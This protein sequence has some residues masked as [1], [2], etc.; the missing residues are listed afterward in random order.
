MNQRSQRLLTMLVFFALGALACASLPART[1]DAVL[2]DEDIVRMVLTGTPEKTI[3]ERIRTEPSDFDLSEEMVS[4]LRIAGLSRSVLQAM[5]DRYDE[6]NPEPE[7]DEGV[8][9]EVTLPP[10]LVI[11]FPS[12]KEDQ[13]LEPL[14]FPGLVPRALEEFLGL[15]GGDTDLKTTGAAL[16]VAC[17]SATHI[18]SHWR[19]RSPLGRDFNSMPRHELLKFY[20]EFEIDRTFLQKLAEKVSKKEEE[21]EE[22]P[23][24]VVRLTLPESIRLELDTTEPHDLL[25][26]VAIETGQRYMALATLE[27]PQLSVGPEGA[28]LSVAVSQKSRPSFRIDLK[29]AGNAN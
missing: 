14:V 9:A 20:P 22:S 8:A 11:H 21:E 2:T 24:Y 17:T 13:P 16:F 10:A 12:R 15:D 3:L 29:T 7:P 28:E 27:I 19:G 23:A 4:E 26:G 25:I 5:Q 18:E 1:A 6:L